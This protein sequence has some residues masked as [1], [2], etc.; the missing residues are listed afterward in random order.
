VAAALRW[1]LVGAAGAAGVDAGA[2][3]G[4]LSEAAPGGG[5]ASREQAAERAAASTRITIDLIMFALT[6]SI[7][8]RRVPVRYTQDLT[9]RSHTRRS[10]RD[11]A[12]RATTSFLAFRTFE[13]YA[14]LA[15][16]GHQVLKT[17]SPL[18]HDSCRR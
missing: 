9:D 8:S 15:G 2:V 12:R 10:A 5:A 14:T 16:S 7:R 18:P 11:F 6:F 1:A 17:P 3:A 13:H 4:A